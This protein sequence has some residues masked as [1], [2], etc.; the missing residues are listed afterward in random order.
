MSPS[1]PQLV[2]PSGTFHLDETF[3]YAV[4]RLAL[5][6]R[7]VGRDHELVR[8]RDEAEIARADLVWDVGAAWEPAAGRFD[9]HQRGA[10]V[11]ED[12]TPFSAAGLVWR[13][14]G[15]AAVQNVPGPPD[16]AQFDAQVGRS[17]GL[18][19]RR[20]GSQAEPMFSARPIPSRVSGR[21]L[22]SEETGF[23]RRRLLIPATDA[24][25]TRAT[26]LRPSANGVQI[27]VEENWISR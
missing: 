13:Y 6:L 1:T 9:H 14:Y 3:A 12:G 25:S 15:E 23:T 11:G 2:T 22:R 4:L 7:E 17:F 21:H 20:Y 27:S 19:R 16:A 24:G 10:P 5:S 8:T 26:P 18:H